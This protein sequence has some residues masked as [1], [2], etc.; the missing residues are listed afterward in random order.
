MTSEIMDYTLYG[1]SMTTVWSP[2][3]TFAS[4]SRNNVAFSSWFFFSSDANRK[5]KQRLTKQ[6]SEDAYIIAATDITACTKSCTV[7]PIVSEYIWL[8]DY[9]FKHTVQDRKEHTIWV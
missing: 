4:D 1:K 3:P 2:T 9:Q 7:I 8:Y 5:K 6:K